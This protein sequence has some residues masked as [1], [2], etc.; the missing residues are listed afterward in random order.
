MEHGAKFL[1]TGANGFIGTRLIEALVERG[2]TVRALSRRPEAKPSLSW[3]RP[4][5]VT[6]RG[7]E[8]HAGAEP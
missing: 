1:V 6:E 8:G 3:A 7:G 5:G 4:G 2:H